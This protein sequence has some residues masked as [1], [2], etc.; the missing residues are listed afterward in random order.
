M[1]QRAL[2]ELPPR[3]DDVVYT[4]DAVAAEIVG[5]L[6][7]NG[8][9]LDPCCGDGAFFRHLPAGSDWCELERGRD[10]FDY[11]ERVDWII[12]NPPYSIFEEWLRHSF[13]IAENVA[14]IVPTN[15]IF[16]RQVI[17][18][19]INNWGG[20]R[21]MMVYGSG[22]VV[23]FPFGFSV[24]TFHFQKGWHGECNLILTRQA[25]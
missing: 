6:K 7:P 21:N 1:S 13:E 11:T 19:M 3:P 18:Q 12:G 16:Q 10:F 5:W 14:Y 20:I 24:G 15:K 23:G 2:F 4:P 8:K 25:A 9:C 17:M 22:A